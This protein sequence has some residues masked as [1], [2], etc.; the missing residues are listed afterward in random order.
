VVGVVVAG[1]SVVVTFLTVVVDLGAVAGAEVVLV[2]AGV[3]ELLDDDPMAGEAP[4]V[5]D[6]P[7]VE[8]P[9]LVED[10]PDVVEAL[11]APLVGEDPVV[12]VEL[13][14][15][16]WAEA[17]PAKRA[18]PAVEPAAKRAVVV[19][20]RRRTAL[21]PEVEVMLLF[22]AKDLGKGWEETQDLGSLQLRGVPSWS[23]LGSCPPVMGPLSWPSGF[24]EGRH[25]RCGAATLIRS[26]GA[27]M[28]VPGRFDLVAVGISKVVGLGADIDRVS[29]FAVL[30]ELAGDRRLPISLGAAEA[31]DL[32]LGLDGQARRRPF[33]PQLTA[34]LLGAAGAS[35]RRVRM[36]RVIDLTNMSVCAATI[37]IEGG[38][39]YQE[40]DARP[41]DALNLAA[42][43]GCPI[44]AT[45]AVLDDAE[46]ARVGDSPHAVL[47]RRALRSEAMRVRRQAG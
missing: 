45:N 13:A 31:M 11:A 23:T 1:A 37:E 10:D 29:Y 38:L 20:I 32:A 4:V 17:S 15:T 19:R 30:D 26:K 22:T 46:A 24:S 33:S 41:S 42:V 12:A 6:D 28:S 5:E 8:E 40:V 47:L 3:P 43:V 2:V 27:H 9:L 25:G 35:L 14:V 18:T 21:R 16:V 34:G 39:G 7:V 44:V 36:D